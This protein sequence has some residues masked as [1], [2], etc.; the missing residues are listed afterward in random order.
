MEKLDVSYEYYYGSDSNNI[1]PEDWLDWTHSEEF[2][3]KHRSHA[4]ARERFRT[5]R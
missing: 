1:Q 2:P 5:H 4:N 3:V